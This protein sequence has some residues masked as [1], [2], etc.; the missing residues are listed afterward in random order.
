[1]PHRYLHI[2]SGIKQ[3]AQ[4]RGENKESNMNRK[5]CVPSVQ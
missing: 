3:W 2:K 4:K 5:S 1:M